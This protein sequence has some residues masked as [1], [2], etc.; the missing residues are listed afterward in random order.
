[1]KYRFF[2]VA[3]S[4]RNCHNKSRFKWTSWQFDEP[5]KGHGIVEVI[6]NNGAQ[7][8]SLTVNPRLSEGKYLFKNL[9]SGEEFV[10]DGGDITFTQPIR[11]VTLWEYKK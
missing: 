6:R 1:M 9:P 2:F 11:S 5:E 3:Y 10:Y 8:E 7:D 4:Q